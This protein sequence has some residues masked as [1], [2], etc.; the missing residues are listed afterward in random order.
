MQLDPQTK[1]AMAVAK[2][3]ARSKEKADA[4]S[5]SQSRVQSPLLAA[6]AARS[7]LRSQGSATEMSLAGSRPSTQ[8]EARAP[9]SPPGPKPPKSFDELLRTSSSLASAFPAAHGLGN[10]SD[11]VQVGGLL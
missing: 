4:G 1:A 6:A 11:A 5:K 7:L 10:S 2:A 8:G 9:R 3:R